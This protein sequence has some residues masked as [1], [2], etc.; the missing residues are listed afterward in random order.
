MDRLTVRTPEGAALK[1]LAT[2]EADAKEE[3]MG[4]FKSAMN[5]LADYEDAEEREEERENERR[6]S[7][8]ICTD[9]EYSYYVEAD[10]ML[11]AVARFCKFDGV[12]EESVLYKCENKLAPI[13]FVKLA[14]RFLLTK[15]TAIL[16]VDGFLIGNI[17]GL[18]FSV[19][20][21]E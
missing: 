16:L 3:L 5:K 11:E 4:K 20:V 19:R 8:L 15:I 17:V 14:N 18:G 13:D 2:N 12:P 6:Y 1:I 9:G 7:Y 10:N 21:V